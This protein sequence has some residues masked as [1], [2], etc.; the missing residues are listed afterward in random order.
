[1]RGAPR[2]RHLV[3]RIRAR[4]QLAGLRPHRERLDRIADA[5]AENQRLRPD[6]ESRV[7]G[8]AQSVL[9]LAERRTT[10]GR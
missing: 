10:R 3:G 6:L 2:R 8:L 5:V 1:M 4:L 9:G 7:E